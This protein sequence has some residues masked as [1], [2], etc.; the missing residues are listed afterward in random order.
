MKNTRFA[1]AA[2]LLLAVVVAAFALY[3]QNAQAPSV[4]RNI[5]L[6]QDM[7]TFPGHEAVMAQV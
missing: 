5:V 2:A 7:T 3:A 6:K 4:K 1:I